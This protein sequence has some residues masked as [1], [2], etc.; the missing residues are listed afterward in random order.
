MSGEAPEREVG[1]EVFYRYV[2]EKEIEAIEETGLLRG[3]R[4]GST[5]WTRDVYGSAAEAK[6]RLALDEPPPAF[7]V[8]FRIRNAPTIRRRGD[9]VLP[10]AGEPGG[11]T[12]WESPDQV[13]VEVIDVVE[14]A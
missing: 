11:G 1:E 7:R 13:E 9:P 8:A 4:R 12:E 5:F 3:G 14:L 2:G 10:A 6:A